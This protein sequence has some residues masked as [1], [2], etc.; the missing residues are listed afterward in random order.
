MA[1]SKV[2]MECEEDLGPISEECTTAINHVIPYQ[3]FISDV[4]LSMVSMSSGAILREVLILM[5][6]LTFLLSS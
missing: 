2:E 4:Y 6:M 3:M 1:A 5:Q